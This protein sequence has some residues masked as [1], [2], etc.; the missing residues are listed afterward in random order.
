MNTKIISTI[1]II[2]L[3][4]ILSAGLQFVAAQ[5]TS[6][7]G[8][9]T[10]MS[11]PSNPPSGNCAAPLNVTASSPSGYQEK[12]GALWV[13]GNPTNPN[14]V[15][16]YVRT[17]ASWFNGPLK[18]MDGTQG[19]GKIL[20]SDADGNTS[21]VDM[22]SANTDIPFQPVEAYTRN[23]VESPN[24]AVGSAAEIVSSTCP[25][26]YFMVGFNIYDAGDSFGHG[27]ALYCRELVKFPLIKTFAQGTSVK[28]NTLTSTD[29]SITSAIKTKT[30]AGDTYASSAVSNRMYT[31]V[32]NASYTLTYTL[33]LNSG[34]APTAKLVAGATGATAVTTYGLNNVLTPG[35]NTITFT[36]TTQAAYLQ[37]TSLAANTANFSLTNVSITKN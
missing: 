28:Y 14:A 19:E 27:A 7:C 1:K 31:L 20:M 25:E 11:A 15:G 3:A 8:G 29:N 37:I 32:K 26:G 18:I 33:T 16:F 21:W 34:T 6:N 30:G 12:L 10:W 17:G 13:N 4:L 23:V 24:N 22:E 36:P 35:T 2:L 5:S 9:D